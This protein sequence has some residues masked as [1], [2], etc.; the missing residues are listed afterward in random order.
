MT[1][2]DFAQGVGEAFGAAAA[3]GPVVLAL[4]AA[5]LAGLVSFASPCCVPLVPGYLSYLAGAT[6]SDQADDR[7][8]TRRRATGLAALFVAGFTV[9]FVLGSASVFGLIGALHLN[10]VLLERLGGVI[11]I[12]MGL[13][14]LGFIPALQRD[15][16]L[17]PRRVAGVAGAPLLGATFGLGWTPC[18]GPTLAGVLSVA[19][20][21]Q[22]IT[23]ARG[24]V[25]IVAYCA[26]LGL[27]FIA[28]AYGSD[29]AVGT[30]DWVRRHTRTIQLIGGLTLI[31]VGVALTSGV[32]GWFTSWLRAEFI[33]NTVL[34]I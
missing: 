3:S 9:V 32:W 7:P 19:A 26:G 28:L 17:Q 18:L 11:T 12:A 8:G 15:I 25:L 21:T 22:G 1:A 30:L 2:I 10:R 16:R 14:F 29:R 31:A 4:G 13:A 27:P 34:P 20:G 24:I 23:A 6:D 33:T 5:S